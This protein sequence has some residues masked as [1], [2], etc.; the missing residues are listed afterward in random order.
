VIAAGVAQVIVGVARL[1]V[2]VN[3]GD[4]TEGTFPLYAAVIEWGPTESEDIE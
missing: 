3:G 4:V 2:R 1:I